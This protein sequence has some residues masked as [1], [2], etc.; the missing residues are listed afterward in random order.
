MLRGQLPQPCPLAPPF[1]PT[2]SGQVGFSG[3][4][5]LCPGLAPHLPICPLFPGACL[6]GLC[7]AQTGTLSPCSPFRGVQLAQG[8]E[9]AR[10]SDRLCTHYCLT[11]GY[12]HDA[13]PPASVRLSPL[14]ATGPEAGGWESPR[15]CRLGAGTGPTP[16]PRP[17]QAHTA[18]PPLTSGAPILGKQHGSPPPSTPQP[19]PASWAVLFPE[20][21]SSVNRAAGRLVVGRR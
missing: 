13:V 8:P 15:A 17:G 12:N 20:E 5:I 2:P 10:G 18:A 11:P 6:P 14:R 16:F 3:L 1:S 19:K 21:V 4:R 9:L 7:L